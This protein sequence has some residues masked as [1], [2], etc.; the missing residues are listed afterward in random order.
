MV[1]GASRKRFIGELHAVS[2]ASDRESDL[3]EMPTDDRL[4]GSLAAAAWAIAQGVSVVR[5]H[6]V[7]ATVGAMKVAAA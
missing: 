1:L 7:A 4:E 2:D 5:V 6:D 3:G